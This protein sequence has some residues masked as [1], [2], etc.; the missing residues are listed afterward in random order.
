MKRPLTLSIV[1]VVAA[2]AGSSAGWARA[3]GQAEGVS[4]GGIGLPRAAWE[5]LHGRGEAGQSLVTYEGG[6]YTV[7]FQGD[8][9]AFV[10]IGWDAPGVVAAEAEAAVSD[11]IPSDARLVET[12]AAPATAG[13][14]IAL[15]LDRYESAA[16][17]DSLPAAGAAPTGGI[18]VVSQETAAPDRFEPNVVR[19]SIATGTASS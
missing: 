7:G 19:V 12:F 13:G 1:F 8:V 11:L 2:L 3:A 9:V 17:L 18:L 10:E 16:L 6:A 4:S 15:R 5:N 14:P